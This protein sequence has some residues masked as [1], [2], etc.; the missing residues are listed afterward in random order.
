MCT[1]LD[2]L[3]EGIPTCFKEYI[4]YCR[5]LKFH[6]TPNYDKLKKFFQKSSSGRDITP[7]FEWHNDLSQN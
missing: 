4:K 3:C 6:E 7:E 1:N 5:K 2:T